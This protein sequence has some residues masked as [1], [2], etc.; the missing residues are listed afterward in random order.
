MQR[1]LIINDFRKSL[2]MGKKHGNVISASQITSTLINVALTLAFVNE[3][4][5]LSGQISKSQVIYR[6]FAG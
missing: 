2:I 1:N 6:K 4:C 3:S 5:K